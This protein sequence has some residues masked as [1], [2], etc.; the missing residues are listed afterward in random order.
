MGLDIFI[1]CESNSPEP[2]PQEHLRYSE[3]GIKGWWLSLYWV[4]HNVNDGVYSI[5]VHKYLS[6]HFPKWESVSADL[7]H[8]YPDYPNIWTKEEHE[9]FLDALVFYYARSPASTVVF[10]W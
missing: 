4:Y 6:Q 2:I 10:S 7:Q 1:N 5:P 8:R 9:K 3:D